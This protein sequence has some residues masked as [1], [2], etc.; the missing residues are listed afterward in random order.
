MAASR[1]A[2]AGRGARVSEVLNRKRPLT[3]AMIVRLR[4]KLGICADILIG[5]PLP[6]RL[7]GSGSQE[8]HSQYPHTETAL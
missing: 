2:G 4:E 8:T 1:P 6:R 5:S 7:R 3:V